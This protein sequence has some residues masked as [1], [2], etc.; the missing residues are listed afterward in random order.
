MRN[1]CCDREDHS[2]P[3]SCLQG[4]IVTRSWLAYNWKLK[5]KSNC[6]CS[7]LI[8]LHFF[9]F[10]SLM[11]ILFPPPTQKNTSRAQHKF[12]K[13]SSE[14]DNSFCVRERKKNHS[15]LIAK[16][17]SI[18]MRWVRPQETMG[19]LVLEYSLINPDTPCNRRNTEPY[20]HR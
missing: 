13:W 20:S 3:H 17:R 1:N 7:L 4:H 12:L 15:A 10:T 16:L 11:Q 19:L 5:I 9:S 14:V 6:Y 8:C 2:Y 18:Y